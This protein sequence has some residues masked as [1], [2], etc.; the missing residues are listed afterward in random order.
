M[1]RFSPKFKKGQ[2]VVFF[3]TEEDEVEREKDSHNFVLGKVYTVKKTDWRLMSG[4]IYFFK[5]VIGRGLWEWQIRPA[6]KRKVRAGKK[7]Y[8]IEVN[9]YEDEDGYPWSVCL[10]SINGK[11]VMTGDYS[12]KR[13][14]NQ[15]AKRLAENLHLEFRR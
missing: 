12:T 8:W 4:R 5:E 15:M 11:E 1:G 2:K 3:K 14:A 13:E 7:K 10:I 9:E 6:I